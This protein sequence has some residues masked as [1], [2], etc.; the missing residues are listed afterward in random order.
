MAKSDRPLVVLLDG[1]N[2]LSVDHRADRLDWLPRT[3]PANVHFILSTTTDHPT[4]DALLA[5]TSPLSKF[6]LDGQ[7]DGDEALGCFVEVPPLKHDVSVG[8]IQEWL[9]Q[10]GRDLTSLQ[11]EIV[12]EALRHCTLPLYTSLIFEEVSV[13]AAFLFLPFRHELTHATGTRSVGNFYICFVENFIQF[14][15]FQR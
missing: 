8:L 1:L 4:F 9:R 7:V 5:K 10:S 14:Q 11:L 3:L 12:K 13:V 15:P 2:Q 6:S